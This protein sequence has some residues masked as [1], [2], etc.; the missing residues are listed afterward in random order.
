MTVL[1]HL[2]ALAQEA[3]DA[4]DLARGEQDA[5]SLTAFL[6][7]LSRISEQAGRARRVALLE[8]DACAGEQPAYLAPG[9]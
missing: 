4:A 1:Y 3:T 7:H 9:R 8:L 2:Q 6:T 5:G